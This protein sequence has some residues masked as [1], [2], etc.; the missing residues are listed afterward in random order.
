MISQKCARKDLAWLVKLGV[1]YCWRNRC[2]ITLS[3]EAQQKTRFLEDAMH[4]TKAKPTDCTGSFDALF[5]CLWRCGWIV[6]VLEW[7]QRKWNISIGVCGLWEIGEWLS[8]MIFFSPVI[9]NSYKW[10][11]AEPELAGVETGTCH[12]TGR[13]QLIPRHGEYP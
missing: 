13:S 4:C 9:V 6:I 1:F 8:V 3:R 11:A 2:C 12:E 10:P 5:S 7:R